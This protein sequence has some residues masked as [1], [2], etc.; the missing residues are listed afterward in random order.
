MHSGWW[1]LSR[2]TIGLLYLRH[3]HFSCGIFFCLIPQPI[4]QCIAKSSNA[5]S[6]IR[7]HFVANFYPK[8][9]RTCRYQI[10]A[11]HYGSISGILRNDISLRDLILLHVEI[12]RY[13]KIE[14]MTVH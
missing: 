3:N 2:E 13:Q 8:N 4:P 5:I 1:G 14:L 12:T 10:S 6:S 7:I 9:N 11:M